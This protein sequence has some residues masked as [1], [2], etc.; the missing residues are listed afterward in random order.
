[1]AN[2]TSVTMN[3]QTFYDIVDK[4]K[5]ISFDVFDTLLLRNI[6][7]PTDVFEIVGRKL[8]LDFDFRNLRIR[9][10]IE[11]RS[12]HRP[13]FDIYEASLTEIYDVMRTYSPLKSRYND[14]AFLKETEIDVEKSLLVRN[15]YIYELYSYCLKRNKIIVV[16]TDTYF[17][18]DFIVEMLRLAGYHGYSKIYI[19]CEVLK[20]KHDGSIYDLIKTDFNVSSDQI[21]HI[22]DNWYSDF[23]RARQKGLHSLVYRKCLVSARRDKD[24]KYIYSLFDKRD[25]FPV[26]LL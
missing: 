13:E 25:M 16:T 17:P 20:A 9:A 18:R 4:C 26:G 11:A 14:I 6:L 5:I 21:I 19:S 24:F 10:N 23:Y 12:R 3:I 15:P 2:F 7:D 22:G 8:N 1:M